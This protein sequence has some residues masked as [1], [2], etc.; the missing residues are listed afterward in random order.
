MK[1]FLLIYFAL[2]V[3]AFPQASRPP[4]T[5]LSGLSDVSISSP[6]DGNA[7]IWNAGTSRWTNQII[8]GGA[9]SALTDVI[10]SSPADGQLL[11]Y[12]SASSKWSNYGPLNFT[13]LAGNIA[14]SQMASGSGASSSSYW[15]GDGTWASPPTG[16]IVP[17]TNLLTGD[18]AGNAVDAGLSG[19]SL[20]SNGLTMQLNGNFVYGLTVANADSTGGDTTTQARINVSTSANT[21]LLSSTGPNF[22]TS[23]IF[24]ASDGVLQTTGVGDIDIA[25]PSTY[26]LKFS[27][28]GGA[29]ERVRFGSGV[30]VGAF[31][32]KGAGTVNVSGGYYVNGVALPGAAPATK[33]TILTSG[34]SFSAT[35]GE[36]AIFVECIAGGGGGGGAVAAASQATS[37]GGGGG[38][39]YSASYI[40][41]VQASYNYTI[42][43]G[44][45]G[46]ANTGGTGNPGG[47]TTWQ[48]SVIVANGGAGGTG[49][50]TTTP[51]PGATGNGGAG[52]A[53]GTGQLVM[54]GSD[55]GRGLRIT[56]SAANA[57][58]G[59]GAPRGG[60]SSFRISG[61]GQ[62]GMQYGGGGSGAVSLTATGNVG[63][64]GAPGVI[65]VT[66]Y[67]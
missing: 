61:A 59:G 40:T 26:V 37:G 30:M 20:V 21:I 66:E 17:V 41:A 14:V 13:D 54:P 5:T 56:T 53:V 44:G 27:N 38:G 10:I 15:R 31:T 46:G 63:G 24:S 58:F 19:I 12:T 49:D 9:L 8:P 2:I 52:G 43:G 36:R 28:D 7:L 48:V 67:F 45:S 11:K 64:T 1:R 62:A 33:V 25:V 50:N 22:V 29:T 47:N 6:V 16:S 65:I 51:V 35:S 57:G 4:V 32:D 55:G 42:G 3:S 39:S 23:G 60:G 18:G 34:T